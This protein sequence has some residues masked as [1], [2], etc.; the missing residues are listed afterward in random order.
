M[1]CEPFSRYQLLYPPFGL[2][3]LDTTAM[4][5]G[6]T[7]AV[8]VEVDLITGAGRLGVTGETDG[9]FL[10]FAKSQIGV[11]VQLSQVTYDYVGA[12]TGLF[13]GAVGLVA[14]A[15]AGNIAGA[16]IAGSGLVGTAA[17]AMRPTVTSL[18]GNGG[19]ADLSGRIH[20]I[21]QFYHMPGEDNTNAGRPLCETRQLSTLAGYQ[22]ILDGDVTIPG[23][24]GEQAAVKA[25]LEGG[26]FYE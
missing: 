23:T 10:V 26:Y 16:L 3:D 6:T 19:Y 13:G 9:K 2:F 20:L 21:A 15:A 1:N 18:G 4:C 14:N 25:F 22:K 24:A 12:A 11:P 5:S 8:G 7:L 17:N